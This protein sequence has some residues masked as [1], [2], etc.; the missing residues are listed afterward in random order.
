MK[1]DNR[2]LSKRYY[3]V[4]G[5]GYAVTIS[6]DAFGMTSPRKRLRR[7]IARLARLPGAIALTA[8]SLVLSVSLTACGRKHEATQPVAGSAPAAITQTSAPAVPVVTDRGTA[9]AA[10]AQPQQ[11]PEPELDCEP[12]FQDKI[13]KKELWDGHVISIS[14]DGSPDDPD[15]SC[16]AKIY[17]KFGKVV[18]QAESHT[19]PGFILDPSTGMDIGGDGSPNV[20]LLNG[21]PA[22][23]NPGDW[24][25][26][27]I[28]LKP[29]PHL[30]FT[31]GQNSPSA[32]F[33]R[34]SQGRIALWA[35]YDWFARLQNSYG[36]PNAERP[37]VERVYRFTDGKLT[38][39]TSDYCV[40]IEQRLF[41]PPAHEIEDFK[42]NDIS[43]NNFDNSEA[44][45]MLKVILQEIFCRR[46]DQALAFIHR[47]WPDQD[48]PN[49]I[50]GL[51]HESKSWNCPEC[52]QGIAAWH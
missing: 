13:G 6:R 47:T 7:A 41:M 28:S 46:F 40:E 22:A 39:V 50:K 33:A 8:A 17:D 30:V 37:H 18:Y 21:A 1:V 45:D 48:Q 35:G 15:A 36:I 44:A 29:Q 26:Q 24:E 34:D 5:L 43:S 12:P 11:S 51:Q 19:G 42:A 27:V 3:G 25:V 49:L 2:M 16:D 14:V 52:E 32:G 10:Q 4:E 20:V 31:F 23:D 38:E 9:P